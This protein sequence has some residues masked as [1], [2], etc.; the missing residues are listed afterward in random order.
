MLESVVDYCAHA[1]DHS[2]PLMPAENRLPDRIEAGERLATAG[3][4]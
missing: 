4:R 1:P 3:V 2:C